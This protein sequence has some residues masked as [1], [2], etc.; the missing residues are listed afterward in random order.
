MMSSE[1]IQIWS[2]RSRATINPE[3]CALV[4]LSLDG[5]KVIPEP[6]VPTHPYHGVL[7]APWPNRIRG[8]KYVFEGKSYQASVNEDFGNALHGL[9]F[10]RQAAVESQSEDSLTLV[11]EIVPTEAYPWSLMLRISFTIGADG[12]TIETTATNNSHVL[13]P[14]ALGTH[15]FFVF[16]EESTLEVRARRASIHGSDMLPIAEIA[17]SEIGFGQGALKAIENVSLDVQ[18]SECE[19]VSAVLRTKQWSIEIWQERAN[20]LMVYT[21]Q[22]FKWADG[23]TRAVAIEP[24]TSAADAFN[25]GAGLYKL[26]P[27]H[28]LTYRWGVRKSV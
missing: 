3:G 28:S 22:A 21:T 14:V 8:G 10:D 15:P 27:G 20:W 9:V 26:S 12:L 4:S 23:R 17:S 18:F 19:H 25:T 5:D 7:L 16:D 1:L 13:A 2:G 24:Q 6:E 11:S